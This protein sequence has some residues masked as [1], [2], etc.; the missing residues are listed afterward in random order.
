MSEKFDFTHVEED[1]PVLGTIV[2][3]LR[4]RLDEFLLEEF[5]KLT[6]EYN[7]ALEFKRESIIL[8]TQGQ[9][10]ATAKIYERVTGENH[11][12]PQIMKVLKRQK[13]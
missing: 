9:M 11:F 12:G 13:V 10:M 8:I 1:V 5:S 6:N 7:E 3:K 2:Q 4:S